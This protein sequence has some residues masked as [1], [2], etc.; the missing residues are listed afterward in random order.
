MSGVGAE[1]AQVVVITVTGK[2]RLE[3]FEHL[4]FEFGTGTGQEVQQGL[5]PA[6][7]RACQLR[8][9]FTGPPKVR[10]STV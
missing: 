4:L 10:H 5:E 1:Q 7:E 2:C 8:T 6:I 9:C 3:V